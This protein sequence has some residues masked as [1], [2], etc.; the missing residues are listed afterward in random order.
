MY[1]RLAI[2]SSALV[3]ASGVAAISLSSQCQSTL[4]T[5]ASS[6]DSTCLNV[7]GLAGLLT[8]PQNQ[9]LVQ[10]INTWLAGA[11]GE[12]PC[13]NQSLAA[14]VQNITSG[15]GSDLSS[16]GFDN[17]STGDVVSVVQQGYPTVRKIACLKQSSNNSLCVTSLLTQIEQAEGQPLSIENIMNDLPAMV[18]GQAKNVPSSIA[19]SDCVKQAYTV[20]KQDE[21]A[22]ASNTDVSN[23]LSSQC[24]ASFIDGSAASNIVEGTGTAAPS[25]AAN[26]AI[27]FSSR[28]VLTG[29]AASALAAV[30]SAFFV[31]A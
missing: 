7:A 25:G 9:S 29:L 1:S 2:A 11:C 20:L 27:S 28:G 16:I 24:G 3:L 19:C 14:I 22:I 30:S 6:P 12:D 5:V 8:T 21:P 26:G 17:S 4:L 31:L 23:A 18:M 13:T 15:C 10:P